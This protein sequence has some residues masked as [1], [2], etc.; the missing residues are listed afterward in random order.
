MKKIIL[1]SL[2][3]FFTLTTFSQ[4]LISRE[5]S[6]SYIENIDFSKIYNKQTG[7]NIPKKEFFKLIEKNPHLPLEKEIGN[8]GEVTRYL[9]DLTSNNFLSNTDVNRKKVEKGE[10]FPNFVMTTIDNKKIE[11]DKLKGKFVILRFEMEANSFR[12]QKQEIID[13][14]NQIN[15]IKDKKNKIESI[16]IFTSPL[17]DIEQ[18]FDLKNSNFNVVANG[19]N[20]RDKFSITSFPTTLVIDKNGFLLDY[21]NRS[22]D[23]DL[24]QIISE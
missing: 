23:I 11:L 15:Q 12:F 18:G 7:E 21:F 2:L 22:V 17:S 8:D 10:L 16:I 5:H 14:D 6:I 1:I 19:R 4:K 3:S 9:V 24:I 13:L 20:F